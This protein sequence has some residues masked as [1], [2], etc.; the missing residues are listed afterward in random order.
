MLTTAGRQKSAEHFPLRKTSRHTT[1]AI[2]RIN[3]DMFELDYDL[4]TLHELAKESCCAF[5]EKATSVVVFHYVNRL[6]T[7]RS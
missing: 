1:A 4:P 6:F 7:C 3:L 5:I 2:R